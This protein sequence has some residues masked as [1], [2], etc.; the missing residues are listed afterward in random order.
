LI[1]EPQITSSGYSWKRIRDMALAHKPVLIRAHILA[2]IAMICSVPVPL[3]LP[4]LVDEVLLH[5]GGPVVQFVQG[6]FPPSWY[7]PVLYISFIVLVSLFLR[8]MTVIFNVIQ[9]RQFTRLSKDIIFR[10]RT[11][12]VRR[13]E[14]ISMA[15]YEVMG[16]GAAAT[17]FITDLDTLDTFIG[18]TVSKALVALFTI[19]GT[20]A[21]LLWMQWK[22]ALIIL[23]FNPVVIYLSIRV[24]KKM[25]E[26]KTRE[27]SAYE[28][29]QEA[30]TE[31]L[32]A[33]Q[34]IRSSNRESHYMGLLWKK[35]RDVRD[36]ATRFEWRNDAGNR[37]SFMLFQVGVDIFRAA[38]M[39]TVVFSGLSIG[40]MFAIF[41]Y[42]WFMMGPVQE[43]LSLQYR[44]YAANGA[45][46]RI[47]TLF[48]LGEEP[49]YPAKSNPFR[50][51]HTVSL[52]V[53][54][55]HFAYGQ[56][57]DVLKGVS[58][59]IKAG[60]KVA[61]VGASGGGKSTLVQVLLGMYPATS[62]QI[63]FD[64]VRVEEIGLSLVREHVVTV[65]QHPALFNDSIRNNLTMGR[66]ASDD[67]LWKTLEIAQ[68]KEAILAL[69]EQLDTQVGR[70]GIRLS[71][72]QR[73][74]LAIARM[75][76]SN[77]AVVVLDEAT[78]ALD[79][80]TEFRLH[81][82]LQQF[83]Q[84]RTTLIIAHRLSA[85]KQADRV[86]VFENGVISESGNHQELIAQNGLY[87]QL[88]GKYQS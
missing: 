25:K 2:V 26:L 76:L 83:L 39:L 82:A 40:Y 28:L 84:G 58:L 56:G 13:L 3:L 49:H 67:E 48:A 16:S 17:H 37:L 78:S 29:F 7:G 23:L 68:L 88:Y 74:R 9:G 8:L 72:G 46:Q 6:L 41:G 52:S 50:N 32:N 42:L 19:F 11:D 87:S 12:M 62:G 14:R 24:A 22:L 63:F 86:Y 31:T 51:K 61:L 70:Q 44:F 69:P 43:I 59:D 73:Q 20:A 55:I 53:K 27:N 66:E 10:I 35:A 4:L 1:V 65:L 54:N 38:A 64:G 33:I 85:V 47:N 30:L 21:I 36:H 45:L 79:T 77:P 75:V 57:E 71:G 80:D 34:Q 81:Q 60:E 5:K 15:E 18:A